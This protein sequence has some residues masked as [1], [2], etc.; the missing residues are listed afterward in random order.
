MAFAHS[1]QRDLLL[2]GSSCT[3]QSRAIEWF[4][5][6]SSLDEDSLM[7]GFLTCKVSFNVL[8]TK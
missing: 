1:L 4:L 3:G 8:E 7:V 2:R 5:K 6:I